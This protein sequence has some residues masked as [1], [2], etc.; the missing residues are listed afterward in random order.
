MTEG[1][2]DPRVGE[3]FH[4]LV[5]LALAIVNFFVSQAI[6]EDGVLSRSKYL[7]YE[8]GF[9]AVGLV[10]A[11]V[12]TQ[13]PVVVTGAIF[14]ALVL[15]A[16]CVYLTRLAVARGPAFAPQSAI[17]AICGCLAVYLALVQGFESFVSRI[18]GLN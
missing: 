15:W 3:S 18:L 12:F 7:G 5:T 13:R 9:L 1:V 8:L 2:L 10:I 17:S 16:F 6:S 11:R 4:I 14:L